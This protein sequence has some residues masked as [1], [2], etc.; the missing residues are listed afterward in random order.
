MR[1][2]SIVLILSLSSCASVKV[3]FEKCT[4]E[5]V[6]T[7]LSYWSKKD[8]A[9]GLAAKYGDLEFM[10]NSSVLKDGAFE[11]AAATSLNDITKKLELN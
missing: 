5:F 8:H 6:C 3:K 10:S 11:N 1:I 9:E 4:S 2:L 7:K